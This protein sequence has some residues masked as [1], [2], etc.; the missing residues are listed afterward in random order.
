MQ[1]IKYR[2]NKM[3]VLK[4]KL[5]LLV[6]AIIFACAITTLADAESISGNVSDGT[7][8][9]PLDYVYVH[10]EGINHGDDSDGGVDEDGNYTIYDLYPENWRVYVRFH[11]PYDNGYYGHA[12]NG[13][14]EITT[15][16]EYRVTINPGDDV[17]D[18][19]FEIQ[20]DNTPPTFNEPVVETPNPKAN[21]PIHISV[22]TSDD[23]GFT[24]VRLQAKQKNPYGWWDWWDMYDTD[25][26]GMYEIDIPDW[27][28]TTAGVEYYV[29]A[30]DFANNYTS[31]P[32]DDPR[33][34]PLIIPPEDIAPPDATI[35]GQVTDGVEGLEGV[36]IE[37]HRED[38]GGMR[39]FTDGDGNYTAEA[40][41]GTWHFMKYRAQTCGYY[42]TEPPDGNPDPFDVGDYYIIE[43]S[44]GSAIE[45]INFTMSLDNTPPTIVN[46]SPE[47]IIGG[48]STNITFE[49][50]ITDVEAM[51]RWA[52]IFWRYEGED[53]WRHWNIN[54]GDWNP[55]D[56]VYECDI[57]VD[58][59]R[60]M[61]YYFHA[62]DRAC[63]HGYDPDPP[64]PDSPPH[65]FFVI[66]GSSMS[67]DFYGEA[68]LNDG[69]VQ[70]GD[71]IT[72]RGEGDDRMVG[73]LYVETEGQYGHLHVYGDD[74]LTGEDEGLDTGEKIRFYINGVRAAPVDP[75]T[76]D[77]V[78]PTFADMADPVNLNLE[79]RSFEVELAQGW[80]KFSLQ[81]RPVD[82]SI[83]EVLKTIEWQYEIVRTYDAVADP[84]D[85][86]RTYVPDMPEESDLTDIDHKHGYWIK[87]YDGATLEVW[88]TAEN[89]Q[90]TPIEMA[91]GWNFISYLLPDSANVED[92]FAPLLVDNHL[93]IVR[94]YK[95]GA[96]TYIPGLGLYNDLINLEPGMGYL[97]KTNIAGT[98]VYNPPSFTPTVAAPT[99]LQSGIHP[100][101]I[102][103]DFYGDILIDGKSAPVGTVIT[104][105]DPEGVL[106]SR[107]TVKKAGR[108]GFQHVYG[109][110][111]TTP[112]DEGAQRG[113]VITFY[114]NGQP[115]ISDGSSVWISDGAL[116]EINLRA[117]APLIPK[118]SMLYQNFPNPFNPETWIPYQLSK[119]S[120]V[121]IKI[122]DVSGRLV[123]TLEL[124]N[125]EAGVY[126]EKEK[127]GYWNGRNNTGESAAS[128]VYFYSI[129]AGDFTATKKMLIL[130]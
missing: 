97:V 65:I 118:F 73:A 58:P 128:G 126:L 6:I 92:A 48:G 114:V 25:G 38:G 13:A 28:V 64:P 39:T 104:A 42:V 33:G 105:Y 68:T 35:S 40:R 67:M 54:D 14:L 130:K 57:W 32:A 83:E 91:G 17:T 37:V 63:N 22:V 111:K 123:Q 90:R 89:I 4:C 61:E 96:K 122:Y 36:W 125:K 107:Y 112:I 101:P 52:D 115:A 56:G 47:P 121:N 87:M 84:G 49:A 66:P 18:Y 1:F 81:V 30:W 51:D 8:S 74:P 9:V 41:A 78:E 113:D 43:V 77:V 60:I 108:F 20:V 99:V 124:G 80:N 27:M 82:T 44:E 5:N 100:T 109:D 69:P 46:N 19:N 95:Q 15:P 129:T 10:A 76:G 120:D 117:H 93:K 45:E 88:G 62:E 34:N 2:R 110:D 53:G 7:G 21:E 106:C 24:E 85:P 50:E 11:G 72:A 103:A 79:A 16:G 86:A 127:S 102:N 98:F 75:E 70:P 31:Y 12:T 23:S 119:D 59:G 29:E 3:Q 26:D 71:L 94:C 55:R 116:I